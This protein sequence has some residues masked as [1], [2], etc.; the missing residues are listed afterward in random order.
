MK[1]QE[2]LS[3][4]RQKKDSAN[5]QASVGID[6]SEVQRLKE[7]IEQLQDDLKDEKKESIKLEEKYE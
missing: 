6:S 1:T 5:N 3:K 2:A 7:K 4:E